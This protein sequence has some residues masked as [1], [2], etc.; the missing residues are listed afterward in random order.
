MDTDSHTDK[1][2]H[3]DRQTQGRT[4]T[5]AHT[6]IHTQG[7]H[8]QID[9]E[10]SHTDGHTQTYYRANGLDRQMTVIKARSSMHVSMFLK[11]QHMYEVCIPVIMN[12]LPSQPK[13]NFA[14]PLKK[15]N[16]TNFY[17]SRDK[18]PQ[19]G[20]TSMYTMV[21]FKTPQKHC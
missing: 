18:Y 20:V 2:T 8:T 14:F 17:H 5:H 11:I 9:T 1:G 16:K 13:W 21:V 12:I 19:R 15:Q 10:Y 7:H 4:H 6:Q 3:T